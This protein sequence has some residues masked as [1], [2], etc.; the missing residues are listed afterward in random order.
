MPSGA[1]LKKK[2]REREIQETTMT[3]SIGSTGTF[4]LWRNGK[5]WSFEDIMLADRKY[6]SR[7]SS[8]NGSKR[9][10]SSIVN[11]TTL[12]TRRGFEILRA[13]K[14]AEKKANAKRFRNG[15]SCDTCYTMEHG[16]LSK[17][18]EPRLGCSINQLFLITPFTR[19]KSR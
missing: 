18:S 10:F 11:V 5:R 16:L 8:K 2:K 15:G 9:K 12:A 19:D 13:A 17:A 14:Q 6:Q 7:R 1:S 3:S 4:H